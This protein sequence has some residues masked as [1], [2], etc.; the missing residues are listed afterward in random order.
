M[1]PIFSALA[2]LA[3]FGIAASVPASAHGSWHERLTGTWRVT[4]TFTDCAGNPSRPPFPSTDSFAE[5]GTFTE[6]GVGSGN[7]RSVGLG[8]WY[9]TGPRTYSTPFQFFI[10][11]PTGQFL[12]RIVD[13]KR[14]IR[15]TGPNTYVA[16]ARTKFTA[17]DGSDLGGGCAEEKGERL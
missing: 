12:A 14:T 5:G 17:P 2:A 16:T 10:F 15:L 6:F 9:R 1:K 11:D 13:V 4:V 8:N 3:A 7:L